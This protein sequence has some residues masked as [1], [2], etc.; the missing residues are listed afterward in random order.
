MLS[1]DRIQD[2]PEGSEQRKNIERYAAKEE[3]KITPPVVDDYVVSFDQFLLAKNIMGFERKGI[4]VV[5]SIDKSALES[6]LELA[7][8][9]CP[10]VEEVFT[11]EESSDGKIFYLRARDFGDVIES[12][13]NGKT[14]ISSIQP[15]RHKVN[16]EM[17]PG[18]WDPNDPPIYAL[19]DLIE[20]IMKILYPDEEHPADNHFHQF[21]VYTCAQSVL[22]FEHGADGVIIFTNPRGMRIK[23]KFDVTTN[24]FTGKKKKKAEN[25]L[26]IRSIGFAYPNER[27]SSLL[28]YQVKTDYETKYKGKKFDLLMPDMQEQLL[29]EAKEADDIKKSSDRLIQQE[30]AAKRAVELFDRVEDTFNIS[31]VDSRQIAVVHQSLP[32][33]KQY[34]PA[35]IKEL[36]NKVHPKEQIQEIKKETRKQMKKVETTKEVKKAPALDLHEAFTIKTKMELDG[37]MET[38]IEACDEKTD[39]YQKIVHSVEGM[40]KNKM[41]QLE[42]NKKDTKEKTGELRIKHKTFKGRAKELDILDNQRKAIE[43]DLRIIEKW[44]QEAKKYLGNYLVFM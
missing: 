32:D 23:V 22:D 5:K 41:A 12:K 34:W 20:F 21:E 44:L 17:P 28:R 27:Y 40:K 30:A 8:K 25:A 14:F 31:K 10:G 29:R 9:E 13:K 42:K 18:P 35:S 2:L 16:P 15:D 39:T 6:R 24:P 11:I 1:T 38:D 37:L 3:K 7:A 19:G 33:D 43:T 26:V 36:Y 4:K